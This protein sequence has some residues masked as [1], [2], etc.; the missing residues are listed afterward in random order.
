MRGVV[1]L[2]CRTPGRRVRFD[3]IRQR[4]SHLYFG[5]LQRL[6]LLLRPQQ[7]VQIHVSTLDT[8]PRDLLVGVHKV[9][10]DQRKRVTSA[11]ERL[12][13]IGHAPSAMPDEMH[14]ISL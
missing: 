14:V 6:E 9:F 11:P 8:L 10:N 2:R 7:C 4:D 3:K 1:E 12:I 13:Q 5:I